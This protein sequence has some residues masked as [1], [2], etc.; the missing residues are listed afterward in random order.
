VQ[1]EHA[2]GLDGRLVWRVGELDAAGLHA[3]AGED[4]RLDDDWLA[5]PRGDL[6]RL[7]RRLREAEVGHRYPG[8]LDDLARLVLEEP[9]A[10]ALAMS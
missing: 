8:A 2:L 4:L 7:L 3:A 5:E 9:H 1:P 6:V 10:G